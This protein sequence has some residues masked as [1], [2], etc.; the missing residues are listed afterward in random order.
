[1]LKIAHISDLHLFVPTLALADLFS[2]RMLGQLNYF[3]KRKAHFEGEQLLK[4]KDL[5]RREGVEYVFV[6]G[7]L[8]STSLEEEFKIGKALFQ[9]MEKSQIKCLFVPG[10]H[11]HY[12]KEAQRDKLFYQ[13]FENHSPQKIFALK[14]HGIEAHQLKEHIWYVGLD[15]A[16]PTGLFV[17][18]RMPAG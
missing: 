3:L 9:E 17:S 18:A 2:K 7:D 13:Y 6:S 14:E 1:M 5:F 16:L 12:T 4:L 8:S 15:T 11:D 10:N